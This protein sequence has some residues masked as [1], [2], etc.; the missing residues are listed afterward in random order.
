MEQYTHAVEVECP[1]RSVYD[2]WTQME[3]F[4]SF[5]E[6]VERVEQVTPTLTRWDVSVAGVHR[7]FD[8]E[9][10]EQVPDQRLVWQ[11]ITGPS[12]AGTVEF[13]PIAPGRTEVQLTMAFEPEGIV[14][15]AGDAL[16]LV[17]RRVQG[18]LERFK[19]FIESRVLPTGEWRGEVHGGVV[20][21]AG[22]AQAVEAPADGS[23]SSIQDRPL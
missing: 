2:Q 22:S 5:L 21:N 15:K 23:I 16:G 8:A 18:D 9:I 4:P 20:T 6:G 12:Q 14:E 10:V 1:V 17:E 13:R 7:T 11:S 3:E 19:S